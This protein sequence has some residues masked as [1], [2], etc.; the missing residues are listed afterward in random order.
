MDKNC[1]QPSLWLT[2]KELMKNNMHLATN[3]MC[4]AWSK[5]SSTSLKNRKQAEIDTWTGV[6]IDLEG[7]Q[8]NRILKLISSSNRHYAM[9]TRQRQ[10]QSATNNAISVIY[11]CFL[12]GQ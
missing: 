6:H 1:A 9:D 12:Y 5:L 11:Q 8:S 2:W 7:P 4:T 10:R 3:Q